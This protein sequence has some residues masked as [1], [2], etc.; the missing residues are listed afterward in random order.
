MR[1][2]LVYYQRKNGK[3]GFRPVRVF[4]VEI[5]RIWVIDQRDAKKVTNVI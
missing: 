4:I 1:D 5:N 2:D 3:V